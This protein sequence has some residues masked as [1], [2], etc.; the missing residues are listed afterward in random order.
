MLLNGRKVSGANIETVIIP[1]GDYNDLVFKCQAVLDIDN[2]EKLYPEPKAPMIIRP[3]GKQDYDYKDEGYLR[4]EAE[5]GNI[6]WSW[7]VLQS[8]KATETLQWETVDDKNPNTWKNW[9]NE[10]RDAGLSFMEIS[11]IERGVM[12][13]NC[14]DEAKI[15][16]ARQR[17][18]VSQSLQGV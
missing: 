10:L 17:F 4:S 8:L 16:E 11:R 6:R 3:G 9:R 1:R 7:I 13:A 14:L 18:T 5:Y 12:A 15:E 2:F